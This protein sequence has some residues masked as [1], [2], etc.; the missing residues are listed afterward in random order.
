[1]AILDP[2]VETAGAFLKRLDPSESHT[3]QIIH[4][5]KKGSTSKILHGTIWDHMDAFL[6]AQKEGNGV[7]VCVN[8]TNMK[9]RKAEDVTAIRAIVADLDGA[10]KEN[11]YR[12]GLV[13][14]VTIESSPGKYHA[15][16]FVDEGEVPLNKYTPLMERLAAIIES[17]HKICDLP[18]VLRVPGFYHQKGEPFQTKILDESPRTYTLAEIEEELANC[19]GRG[20]TTNSLGTDTLADACRKI[21]DAKEGSINDTMFKQA[22]RVVRLVKKRLLDREA[23]LSALEKAASGFKDGIEIVREQFERSYRKMPEELPVTE[24]I[25]EGGREADNAIT[26]TEHLVK[27][28]K[29]FQR[30][31]SLVIP[32]V[33]EKKWGSTNSFLVPL[34]HEWIVHLLKDTVI[35]TKRDDRSKKTRVT[36]LTR[37]LSDQILKL[38]QWPSVPK[39]EGIV[40]TPTLRP[41]GSILSTPGYDDLT[42]YYLD[43]D[44][45]LSMPAVADNPTR[46][47]AEAARDRIFTLL[48]EV[49]FATDLDRSVALSAALTVVAR[50]AFG[51]APMFLISANASSTGKSYLVHLLTTLA[52]GSPAP[53]VGYSANDDEL[54][55]RLDSLILDAVPCFSLDNVEESISGPPKLCQMISED[56]VGVRRL[57][58]TGTFMCTAR[59]T[60]FATGNGVNF[61]ADMIRRG[62]TC[63]LNARVDRPEDRSFNHNPVKEVK[64]NRGNYVADLLTIIRAYWCSAEK[65]KQKPIATFDDWAKFCREPIIWLG[66]VDPL[67]TQ[68]EARA[69]DDVQN[70]RREFVKFL[71][72]RYPSERDTIKTTTLVKDIEVGASYDAR[73]NYGITG[74][75]YNEIYEYMIGNLAGRN[76]LISKNRLGI[77]LRTLEDVV[78][79]G[80]CLVRFKTSSSHGNSWVIRAVDGYSAPV[81]EEPSQDTTTDTPF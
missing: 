21:L 37:D 74:E 39:C 44:R 47:D 51:N 36:K 34:S 70:A 24:I 20:K 76:G 45:A 17:D 4:D 33:D 31:R 9:G 26:I 3:F 58:Q 66:M 2:D 78:V 73:D 23:A 52:C 72:R 77:F 10:P 50:A 57:G 62:L 68:I 67:E 22:S 71:S 28:G 56:V 1:M 55:K 16:W 19:E 7:Y 65:Q 42:G 40:N 69:K 61:S 41:N 60:I 54:E 13:P 27:T 32:V 79:N 8:R 11:I 48:D 18:R 14:S 64:R 80:V 15:W 59:S 25:L 5:T 53:V 81:Q 35:F 12:F 38:G 29:V 63:R 49:A 43:I 6:A 75:E 30:G 46:A